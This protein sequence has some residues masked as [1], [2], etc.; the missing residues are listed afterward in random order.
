MKGLEKTFQGLYS[1]LEEIDQNAIRNKKLDFTVI[2]QNELNQLLNSKMKLKKKKQQLLT[3]IGY[4]RIN[5]FSEYYERIQSAQRDNELDKAVKLMD[6]CVEI[7][8]IPFISTKKQAS[9]LKRAKELL[10]IVRFP[11]PIEHVNKWKDSYK[12]WFKQ[13]EQ[14]HSQVSDKNRNEEF[15]Q[16][17][18]AFITLYTFSFSVDN[19]PALRNRRSD[20]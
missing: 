17:K 13:D 18:M 12:A 15:N 10:S 16:L 4:L 7:I 3:Q 8:A 9:W 5:L 20:H 14:P 1:K 2:S 11:E 19:F 6:E